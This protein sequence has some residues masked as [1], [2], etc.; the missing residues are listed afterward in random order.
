MHLLLHLYL[1]YFRVQVKEY[2][3][4]II[5][6]IK[7]VYRNVGG[8][9]T[10]ANAF[11]DWYNQKDINIDIAIIGEACRNKD[12]NIQFRLRYKMIIREGK[13]LIY[14]KLGM[15]EI[16]KIIKE[17]KKELII[18][19]EG[20]RVCEVYNEYGGNKEDVEK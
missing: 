10:N 16:T 14:S 7:I 3:K 4:S 17:D 18:E 11:L 19:T 9:A 5:E 8:L 15:K 2:T 13:V 12:N 6:D 20:V 1:L